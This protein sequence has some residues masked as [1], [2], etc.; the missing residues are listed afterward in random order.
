M[1][2]TLWQDVRHAVRALRRAPAFSATV[3]ATSS[4]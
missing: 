2:E 4:T 3:I 1:I